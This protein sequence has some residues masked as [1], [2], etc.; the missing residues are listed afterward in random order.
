MYRN[1]FTEANNLQH[2]IMYSKIGTI[3]GLQKILALKF[4]QRHK[5]T[6]HSLCLKKSEN[7]LMIE[8]HNKSENQYTQNKEKATLR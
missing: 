8:T 5:T 4:Q 2:A 7:N 6:W 1:C 3:A